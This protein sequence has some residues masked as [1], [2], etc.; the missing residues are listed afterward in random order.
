MTD[1]HDFCNLTVGLYLIQQKK[2]GKNTSENYRKAEY[3]TTVSEF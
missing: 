1:I 3:K 2:M